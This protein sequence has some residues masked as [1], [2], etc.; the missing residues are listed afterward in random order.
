M[1]RVVI[2]D[3]WG[4]HGIDVRT[5]IS[6]GY[7]SDISSQIVILPLSDA[8]QRAQSDI[9]II[10]FVRSALGWANF[11]NTAKNLYPR[12]QSFFPLGSNNFELLNLWGTPEPS[13]IV[14]CGAGDEEGRNNTG[15][16]NG[17]EFWDWDLYQSNP[18]SSDQSSFSN[19][20]IAGKLLKIKDTLNCTWWEARY[21]ARI[22]AD[23][24]ESNRETYIWDSRNGFGRISVAKAI[25]ANYLTIPQDPY[26]PPPPPPPAENKIKHLALEYETPSGKALVCK[27]AGLRIRPQFSQRQ[28][29]L[30]ATFHTES[31]KNA[32]AKKRYYLNMDQEWNNFIYKKMKTN[33]SELNNSEEVYEQ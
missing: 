16:G 19:G 26:I 10:A 27:F 25:A 20:I 4:Q 7:G 29:L 31:N 32:I 17:L 12:V 15:Y 13:L 23:R 33:I 8:I 11:I 5:A 30:D 28:I 24:F 6:Q 18:P 1:E 14:T 9:N 21:R 3:E 2:A 22:T